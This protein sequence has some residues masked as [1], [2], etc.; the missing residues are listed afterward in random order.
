MNNK[1]ELTLITVYFNGESYG[2][3][4]EDG[5]SSAEQDRSGMVEI[6]ETIDT[7]DSGG[8]NWEPDQILDFAESDLVV[9]VFVRNESALR[10]WVS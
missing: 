4:T 1:D 6:L 10:D 8:R 2:I 5:T 7:C 9:E 3:V